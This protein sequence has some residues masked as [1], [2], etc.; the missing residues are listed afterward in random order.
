MIAVQGRLWPVN[1]NGIILS[2]TN[3]DHLV[4]PYDA[5]IRDAVETYIE[6]LGDALH[7]IYITGSVP[8]GLALMGRSDVD[9]FAV[10][11]PDAAEV[12]EDWI[13]TE[14]TRLNAGYAAIN[15]VR[16]EVWPYD[17]VFGSPGL[18]TVG[19]FIVKTQSV[20]VWGEDLEPEI[21]PFN[22]DDIR[23]RAAVFNDDIIQIKP[24]IKA[25]MAAVEADPSPENVRHWCKHICKNLLRT[26]FGLVAVNQAIY[27]RDVDVAM[28]YFVGKYPEQTNFIR[29][30]WSYIRLPTDDAGELLRFLREFGLWIIGE[31]EFWLDRHNPNRRRRYAF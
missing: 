13:N 27:T 22:F 20:C 7:S 2:D 8:R 19:A 16:L 31:S 12:A 10:L 15:G 5:I 9:F 28:L 21:A 18:Y 1:E 6:H 24:D 25:A 26:G 23:I 17:D 4:S 30:A 3:P 14:E 11:N 29:A